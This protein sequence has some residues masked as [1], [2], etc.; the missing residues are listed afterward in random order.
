M[1]LAKKILFL[2][3]LM[4]LNNIYAKASICDKDSL[5]IVK[6]RMSKVKIT[7]EMDNDYVNDKG[8]KE[9]GMYKIIVTGL[10][11]YTSI[12]SKELN[13]NEPY[14]D[15]NKGNITLTNIESGIK[16]VSIYYDRCNEILITQKLDIPIFNKYSQREECNG[17]TDLDVCK[18]DY[19]YQLNEGTFQKKLKDYKEEKEQEKKEQEANKT[20]TFFNNVIEFLKSCYLYIIGGIIFIVI[21]VIY[22]VTRKKKY[23]LE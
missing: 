22:I 20:S 8:E 16:R 6:E 5:N 17:I 18:E 11:K 10:E 1:R 14:T 15:E 2:I 7:Y 21:I 23:T 9:K 19:E 12:R 4:L 13:I 3:V